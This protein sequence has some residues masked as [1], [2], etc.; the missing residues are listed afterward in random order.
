MRFFLCVCASYHVHIDRMT[1]FFFL[2]LEIKPSTTNH[3]CEMHFMTFRRDLWCDEAH[4][5]DNTLNSIFFF[6]VFPRNF[7][8]IPFEIFKW[9]SLYGVQSSYYN[10]EFIFEG[11]RPHKRRK[12][13]TNSI[14]QI[15]RSRY[16]SKKKKEETAS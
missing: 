16:S 14:Q 7:I 11:N 13:Y 5:I 6:V 2:F 12:K 1:S 4:V 9:I 10:F 8:S 3:C 15:V